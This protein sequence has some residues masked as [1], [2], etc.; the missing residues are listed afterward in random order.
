MLVDG[1]SWTKESWGSALRSA[2]VQE[3]ADHFFTTRQLW[4]RGDS[5][6]ADWARTASTVGVP[7]NRLLRLTQ[8]HGRTAVAVRRGE[9][10]S[11]APFA[12]ALAG[13]ASADGWPQAD[14]LLTD[15]PSV[16]LAVQVADCVPLLIADP[17]T[18]AVGAV[19]AGWRGTV[20]GAARAAV[21]ELG[22][23]FGAEARDLVVAVGPSIGACCYEVGADVAGAFEAAHQGGESGRWFSKHA[24]GRLQLDL[25]AANRDQLLASGVPAAQIHECGLCTASHPEWFASYRRDGPGTGRIAAVIRSRPPA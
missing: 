20:A 16:A 17:R 23:E 11:L 24:D 22:R 10:S 25:W 21:E 14:I 15:D 3:I 6:E 12:S 18:G 8:V 4:L 7:P 5:E 13:D 9:A 2:A 1:F 19:H